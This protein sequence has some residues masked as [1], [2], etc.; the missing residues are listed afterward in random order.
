LVFIEV[1]ERRERGG[2][3][4]GEAWG[5]SFEKGEGYKRRRGSLLKSWI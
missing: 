2:G 4:E 5:A 1:R 3:G